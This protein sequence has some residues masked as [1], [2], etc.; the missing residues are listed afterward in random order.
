[1]EVEK[2][3]LDDGSTFASNSVNPREVLCPSIYLVLVIRGFSSAISATL[4]LL[5]Y[6][7]PLMPPPVYPQVGS[8][9]KMN[10][11]LVLVMARL[12]VSNV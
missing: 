3:A 7:S 11:A 4:L 10:E 8:I 12:L 6:A 9:S 1:M 5:Q 2:R